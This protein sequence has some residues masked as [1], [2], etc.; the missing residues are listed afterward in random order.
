ML[1]F[2][3]YDW[4][5]LSVLLTLDF[6][7]SCP[8][9][10]PQPRIP[11]VP[12]TRRTCGISGPGELNGYNPWRSRR[13]RQQKCRRRSAATPRGRSCSRGHDYESELGQTRLISTYSPV[14]PT[15]AIPAKPSLLVLS[16]VISRPQQF[17][18]SSFTSSNTS[19]ALSLPP[20]IHPNLFHVKPPFIHLAHMV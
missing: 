4:I 18:P 16:P 7:V 17:V 15:L 19:Q 2:H 12:P 14:K 10:L 3:S 8:N 6:P 13:Q 11:P 1:Y 20:L 5:I 9:S